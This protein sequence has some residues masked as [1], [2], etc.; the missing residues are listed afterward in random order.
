MRTIRIT[1][2]LIIALSSIY[3]CNQKETSIQEQQDVHQEEE[4]A[5]DLVALTIDQMKSIQLKVAPIEKKQL[6]SAIK[7][8]GLIK[9]PNQ[10]KASATALMG[11]VVNSILVQTGVNV[12]KG[13]VIAT[14]K[15]TS[16]IAMQEEYL[17]AVSSASLAEL[18]FHRQLALQNGNAGALK[19]LQ[20]AESTFKTMST[21]K[22]SLKKQLELI[23][24]NTATLNSENLKSTIN[25]VSPIEG[26]IS[27]VLVNIGSFVDA[28]NPVAEIVDN[29]QLHLDLYVYERD[30]QKLQ[31][32]QS[33]HFNVTNN[34]EKEY[35][36]EIYAI[37]NTFEQDTK[38][39][40]V[41]AIV[42]GN[43][44]GLIDGTNIVALISLENSLVD[45]VPT[46]AIINSE[47][48]DYIF[49]ISDKKIED[50]HDEEE[51][52]QHDKQKEVV[53]E[54]IPVI[55]G[56][57]AIGY[58]E[59]TLLKSIPANSKIVIN[60]AFFILAKQKNKGEAHAH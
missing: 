37:S 47:G 40:A 45:A 53:F 26:T 3:S 29:M 44:A 15:N 20:A 33:I 49:I 39:V 23:G 18:E 60:G 19:N 12:K 28:Y 16:F 6:S 38:A 35:D 31:V 30:L 59:I 58:S 55:K 57:T 2:I 11:G 17:N 52:H 50:K 8:N 27:Q 5:T 7:V 41:H 4:V 13:Q 43:K 34:T 46:S 56:T 10:N 21:K 48:Q 14:L 32:G 22:N 51:A 36:A 54:K 25:I 42:K 9:V 24:I 1:L